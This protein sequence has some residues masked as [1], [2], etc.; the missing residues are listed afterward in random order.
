MTADR[1]DVVVRPARPE[2]HEALGALTVAA[3]RALGDIHP[4]DEE[5]A[6]ELADVAGRAATCEVLVA[7]SDANALL[8]GVTWI[9]DRSDPVA[10]H[11]EPTTGSFRH[12]A[13]A[14]EAQGRG[15][16][17]ALIAAALE[18][19]H[20]AGLA[21]VLIHVTEDNAHAEDLY[22]RLGFARRSDLDWQVTGAGGRVFWLHCL[23]L[24]LAVEAL[25]ADPIHHGETTAP[26]AR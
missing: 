12:L 24:D 18:R 3:Y 8:G 19:A 16:G 22:V 9:P 2:E 26:P 25:Q 7:V 6:Q 21:R 23:V 5:Y 15:V 14:P 10:E 20:A 4:L 11:D 1:R 17:R 13:V